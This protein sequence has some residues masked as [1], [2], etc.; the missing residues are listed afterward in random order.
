MAN[1]KRYDKKRRLLKKGEQQ[2]ADGYYVYRWTDRRGQRHSVNAKTLEELREKEEG[3]LKNSIDG[4]RSDVKN[5]TV[6]DVYELWCKVKR[7][8]KDNTFQNYK[9][10]YT[11][12]VKPQFG[13][14]RLQTL[15][16]SDVK[17]FYNSLIEDKGLKINTIDNIHSVLHQV[18]QMAVEDNYIRANVSDGVMKELKRARNVG[19]GHRKALTIQ[20]QT[21]FLDFLKPENSPY[22][23]W[24]PIF[25]VMVGTGMRVGE[26][27]G[28]RW[29]DVDFEEGVIEVNHT[30]VYYSHGNQGCS[31]NVHT[32]KTEAGKR[33]IPMLQSV[34][35]ALLEE[36]ELQEMLETKCTVT[37]DGYTD[38]IF[39][40]R[41][42]GTQHQGTLNKALRRIIRDCNEKQL[43]K[44]EKEPVLLPSFSCHSLRHT[45]TTR[46][47]E[48]GVN[49]K[50]VQEVLGHKNVSITLDIYT[51]VT[52]ELA[53]KEFEGLEE[54]MNENLKS[55]EVEK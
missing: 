50:V 22:H 40:N 25:A 15:K 24:Y 17:Q 31:F 16:K 51:D 19:E 30:L 35:E 12:F 1:N 18:L 43:E 55:A 6:N 28:L 37:I 13:E 9:Y 48:S 34:K 33:T 41:F 20:E 39:I 21:L 11:M 5:A 52:K 10:M 47:V 4:I 49:V 3:I 38:F 42:G 45:F 32:P 53:R 29:C 8:L 54:K 26:A 7:G 27:T 46:M 14:L 44:E 23:R 36:K 2:R